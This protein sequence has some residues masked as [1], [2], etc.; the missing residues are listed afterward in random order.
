VN[1]KFKQAGTICWTK[2]EYSQSDH[3]KANSHIG[4]FDLK[5]YPNPNQEAGW[6]ND[7]PWSS[8]KRPLAGL[9]VVGLTRI[10]AGPS[11]TRGPAELGAS[12]MRVTAPH[13]PDTVALH[14]DLNW[15]KW[16]CEL[17]LRTED[18]REKLSALI[19]ESDVVVDGYRPGIMKKYGFSREDIMEICKDRK[20]GIIHLRENCYG[21]LL[22][23]RNVC[24]SLSYISR[25]Q[26]RLC[27]GSTQVYLGLL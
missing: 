6:W 8:H 9:K 12:V 1:S 21:W 10:I 3:G 4:L 26:R 18:G 22:P 13:I 14:A 11:I 2:E 16:N 20:R 27:S 24:S 7:V 19:L 15:A 5:S 25:E 17:D 23:H